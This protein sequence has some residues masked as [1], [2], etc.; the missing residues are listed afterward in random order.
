MVI[1]STLTTSIW[2]RQ[3][4]KKQLTVRYYDRYH[5]E[6]TILRKS[7]LVNSENGFNKDKMLMVVTVEE[8]Q[9]KIIL[10]LKW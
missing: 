1:L 5:S 8:R 9:E 10:T 6:N 4:A 3:G 7:P 2:H